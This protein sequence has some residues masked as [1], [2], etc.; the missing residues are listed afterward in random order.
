MMKSLV[1]KDDLQQFAFATLQKVVA[2]DSSSDANSTTVPST[3]GQF[4]LSQMASEIFKSLGAQVSCDSFANLIAYFPGKAKGQNLAPIA[5]MIHLD[6]A[7]G[8]KALPAL[9]VLPNWDGQTRI[10]YRQNHQIEVNLN[11]YPALKQ[12]VHQDL[13]YGEGDYPFGLDDKLG[14]THIISLA[15]LLSKHQDVADLSYPPIYLIGRPDEEIGSDRALFA[16]ADFL[17]SKN[18]RYAYTIDGIEPFEIN[19]A[20]FNAALVKMQWP[21]VLKTIDTSAQ[22]AIDSTLA[23][24]F[25][26]TLEISGV[27]THGAT[28]HAEGYRS[29]IRLVAEILERSWAEKLEINL[30]EYLPHPEKVCDGTLK[31]FVKQSNTL[32]TLEKIA[33]SIVSAHFKKGANLVFTKTSI[34]SSDALQEDISLKACFLA[35]IEFMKS[36]PSFTLLAE[37]SAG[38]DGYSNPYQLFS[39]GENWELCFRIRDF[40][41]EGLEARIRHLFELSL[42]WQC[43]YQYHRQYQNMEKALSG[44]PILYE[45]PLK[46][47]ESLGLPAEIRPIRGGTGV[48]PFLA[49]GILVGNLGTGYFAPESEKEFTTIQ[50]LSKSAEWLFDICQRFCL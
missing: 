40:K 42:R 30:I 22:S 13:I 46:S 47:S 26:C 8:T 2:I 18:V 37:D 20:N 35:L 24:G 1:S 12:F 19:L 6:T 23:L 36:K 34:S 29:P 49:R 28:A 38:W 44:D 3:Q 21:K 32:E 45:I 33:Q 41:E 50:I 7:H 17:Q 48:D 16:L 10:P 27:N 31:I 14:F 5:M 4:E 9:N 25:M 11:Q 43:R 15:Y 39:Q